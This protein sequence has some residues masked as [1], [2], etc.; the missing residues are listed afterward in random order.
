[1]GIAP[2]VKDMVQESR[3]VTHTWSESFDSEVRSASL[4]PLG[5]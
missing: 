4:R 1:M 5:T 2:S 3:I